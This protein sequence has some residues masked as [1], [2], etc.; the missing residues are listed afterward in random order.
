MTGRVWLSAAA[1]AGVLLTVYRA[2]PGAVLRQSVWI[3][4]VAGAAGATVAGAIARRPATRRPWMLVAG[5]LG[6]L[7]VVNILEF[8]VWDAGE[9]LR[10]AAALLELAAFPLL[11]LAALAFVRRQTPNGDRE[12]AI[13]GLIVMVALATLLSQ[14]V[15]TSALVER[16]TLPSFALTVV[17]PLA[18]AGV[19]TASMRLLLVGGRK[20]ASTWMIVGA[21]VCGLAGHVGRTLGQVDGSYARGGAEDLLIGVA[22]AL[23]GIAALHPSMVSLT[24]PAPER[25]RRLT[26][27]RVAILGLALLAAPATLVLTGRSVVPLVG[28]VLLSLL[29]LMRLWSLVIER[30]TVRDDMREQATHDPLTGLPNRTSL[31]ERLDSTL[32]RLSTSDPPAAVLFIDLDGFK[33]ANDDFGHAAGD[34]LLVEVAGRLQAACRP[35]DLIGRLSGDEFVL[36]CERIEPSD[37]V[38]LAERLL[39][40]LETPFLLADAEVRVGASVG[41]AFASGHDAGAEQLLGHADAAMYEAKQ[42][43]GSAYEIYG[44]DLGERLRRRRQLEVDLVEAVRAGQLQVAY[45]PIV[46]LRDRRPVGHEALLRWSHPA[47]GAIPA[48]ETLAVAEATGVLRTLG[49]WVLREACRWLARRN[50][51]A[52]GRGTPLFVNVSPREV[53]DRHLPARVAGILQETGVAAGDLVV[54]VTESALLDASG[55]GL[56]TLHGLRALGVR[57]ALD[58]FGVGFSCLSHLRQVPFDVVKLDASFTRDLDVDAANRAIVEAVVGIADRLG[59]R[60][61]GE[62]I[63]HPEQ[64]RVLREL[65]CELGQGW[66]LGSPT[67]DGVGEVVSPAS[68]A[69][70]RPQA[71]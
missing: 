55:D 45:Q 41:V 68:R 4:L 23:V 62:G 49:T 22:Y 57:I 24:D 63:E 14:T 43:V 19:T 25:Q 47:L 29:V 6:L 7:V 37:V 30:E 20:V 58:D 56:R 36:V 9:R 17:A 28:S 50:A 34:Q 69:V 44:R 71:G 42:R 15:F 64:L 5:G 65:G 16:A 54:E 39:L 18:L 70:V 1:A 35:G 38:R 67:V 2:A 26:H 13:D 27:G 53:M 11:G 8:P 21:T 33:R 60:V 40:S 52:G 51:D 32:S 31:L 48:Q 3:A 12:G 46:S 59:A 61:V 10:T 66:L